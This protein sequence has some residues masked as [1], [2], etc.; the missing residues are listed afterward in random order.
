MTSK[1]PPLTCSANAANNIP[2][3]PF[4]YLRDNNAPKIK[5]PAAAAA[6]AVP[7]PA[8]EEIAARMAATRPAIKIPLID[9]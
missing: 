7:Y 9:I 1:T 5:V 8:M 6:A 2:F 3:T 4:F